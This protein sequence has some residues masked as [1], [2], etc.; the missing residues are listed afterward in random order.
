MARKGEYFRPG[1]EYWRTEGYGHE[2]AY[3]YREGH[4]GYP[5]ARFWYDEKE[6]RYS[7]EFQMPGVDRKN[8]SLDMWGENFCLWA[9][10][11]DAEYSGCYTFPHY[12]NP[13]KAQAWY[14]NGVL[15]VYAPVKD[16]DKRTHVKIQ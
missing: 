2:S 5:Y 15:K 11:D 6:G 10:K 7:Y 1:E 4:Y 13:E 12:V 14:E 3:G 16:W 8:I 9:K